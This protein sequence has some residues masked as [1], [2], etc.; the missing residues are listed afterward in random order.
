MLQRDLAFVHRFEP[1]K[2]N[3]TLL[4]LHGTGGDEND[5]IDLGRAIDPAAA[6]LSPR[7]KVLEHGAPRFFRRLAEGVFDEADVVKRAH[8]LADFVKAATEIY[9]MDPNQL[10]AVGYSNGANIAAAMMLLGLV[11]FPNAVLLRP[12]VPLSHLESPPKLKGARVLLLAGQFD[13]IARL[14]IVEALA[15]LF[16][17]GGAAVQLK[18]E[19]T[20]HQLTSED[21]TAARNWL[22][23]LPSGPENSL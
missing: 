15:D 7:G 14:P 21:V 2:T 16:R 12:M 20:G 13:P 9:G 6:L 17:Q 5:L 11:T 10:V 18:I 22:N 3:R 19:P 8:E 23:E 4:L 1:G